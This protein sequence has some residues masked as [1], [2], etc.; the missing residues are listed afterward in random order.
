MPELPELQAICEVLSR[1]IAGHRIESV[2]ILLPIVLR[3]LLGGSAER[4]L[5]GR[6]FEPPRRRGKFLILPFEH[7]VILAINPMLTGRLQLAPPGTKRLRKTHFVLSLSSGDELRY[8]DIKAM[9]KI[10]LTRDLEAIPGF[11]DMGPDA[12]GVGE[13]EFRARLGR[14][15]GEIKNILTNAGF[16]AGIGNAYADEILH[17]AKLSPFRRRPS[18]FD[19]EIERLFRA[20]RDVLEEAIP[21]VQQEMGEDITLKPRDWL[22]VHLKGGKPCPVCGTPISEIRANQRITSYCR[23]CQPGTLVD[24][25]RRQR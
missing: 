5:A 14:H 1:R 12:L 10:Y 7:G 23:T 11:S 24:S 13:G 17:R 2:E 18:L 3:N 6:T 8:S 16:L 21:R 22:T 9:G 15:P 4:R 25:W 19:E 20:V